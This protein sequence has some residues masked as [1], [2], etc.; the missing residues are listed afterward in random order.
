MR[1]IHYHSK[2]FTGVLRR[3]AA[4]AY[5]AGREPVAP[6]LAGGPLAGGPDP[7]AFPEPVARCEDSCA[8]ELLQRLFFRR[9]IS[10]LFV[11]LNDCVLLRKNR[12]EL[13]PSDRFIR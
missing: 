2:L 4:V 9:R 13:E 3:D 11:Y 7:R 1:I 12:S 8:E 6:R 5:L 10:V